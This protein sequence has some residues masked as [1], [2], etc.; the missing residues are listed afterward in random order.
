[1]SLLLTDHLRLK[2]GERGIAYGK[3]AETVHHPD[4]TRPTY[5]GREERYKRF[6]KNYLMVVVREE[7]KVLIVI[8]T[9]W[10]GRLPKK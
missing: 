4:F 6:G 1:M 2:M 10:V 8:T 5:R 7:S 9:H 3:V